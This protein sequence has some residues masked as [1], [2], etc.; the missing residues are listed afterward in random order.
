MP[1]QF[2]LLLLAPVLL[3]PAIVNGD[4]FFFPDTPAYVR[5]IDALAVRAL[6]RSSDWTTARTLHIAAPAVKGPPSTTGAPRVTDENAPILTGRSPF[7]G[8]LAYLGVLTGSFWVVIALQALAAMAVLIGVVRHA[9]DPARARAFALAVA[10]TVAVGGVTSLPYFTAM[11]MP[12]IFA[13]LA[14]VAAAVLLAGWRRETHA[15][16]IGWAAVAGYG[17]LTHSAT[18]LILLA[19]A[20]A[21]AAL[22]VLLRRTTS[23]AAAGIGV[24]ALSAALGLAGDTAFAIA[25]DRVTGHPPIRPPFLTARLTADGVGTDFARR[26]CRDANWV[27]C[28]YRDRLP[29]HSDSFLWSPNPAN[30]VFMTIPPAE[31]RALSGEQMPFVMAVLRDNPGVVL[32]SSGAA[33][34]DQMTEVGLEEFHYSP[35]EVDGFV[36]KMPTRLVARIR[37]TAAYRGTVPIDLVAAL[38]W[39]SVLASALIVVWASRR[40]A[41]RAQATLGGWVVL[42]WLANDAICGAMST[43]HDRYNMRVIWALPIVAAVIVAAALAARRRSGPHVTA[44]P[45]ELPEHQAFGAHP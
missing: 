22:W 26:H 31:A 18:T 28:R 44:L 32:R 30:G 37:D 11:L 8:V 24:V 10:A 29:L 40:P 39:P 34:V 17:A 5:S 15:G 20:G 13:G 36:D 33:I 6:G 21:A 16:R 42:G 45:P 38:G 3:W 1:R 12:D 7:Y 9:I 27:L 23:T 4:A 2:L 43:P 19:M 25:I 41:L 14:I 35:E